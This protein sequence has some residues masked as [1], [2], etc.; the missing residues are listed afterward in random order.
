MYLDSLLFNSFV[1]K[2]SQIGKINE[3]NLGIEAKAPKPSD[4]AA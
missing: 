2:T 1:P 4:M 3:T